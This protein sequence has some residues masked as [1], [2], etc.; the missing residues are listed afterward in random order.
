MNKWL[1]NEIKKKDLM[2]NLIIGKDIWLK[3]ISL[4]YTF[5]KRLI[6]MSERRKISRFQKVYG[7][8]KII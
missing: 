6:F 7:S 5:W 2:G 3:I 8:E 4:P 1:K